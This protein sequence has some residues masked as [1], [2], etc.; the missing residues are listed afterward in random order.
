VKGAET[1]FPKLET[2]FRMCVMSAY[3]LSTFPYFYYFLFF[4]L[5]RSHFPPYFQYLFFL[6]LF[7]WSLDS[8]VGITLGYGLNDRASRI[9]FPAGAGNFSLHH[10][11]QNGSGVHPA[12]YTMGTGGSFFGNKA[13]GA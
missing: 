5:F 11:I 4:R 1:S 9:R 13:A 8:S 10:R 7:V 12:S 3:F 2:F 6:Y